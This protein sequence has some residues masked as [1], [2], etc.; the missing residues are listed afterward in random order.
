LFWFSSAVTEASPLDRLPPR[1][2]HEAMRIERVARPHTIV[3]V[4]LLLA[5]TGGGLA[6]LG[7]SG[8]LGARAVTPSE[9]ALTIGLMGSLILWH[10]PSNRIGLLLALTGVLF[11]VSVLA[12]GVLEYAGERGGAPGWLRQPAL[13]WAW[14]TP[15][16]ALPWALFLLWF[17]DGRFTS[18]G[19]KR[20]F[21]AATAAC[22]A[23]AVVGY[24][25]AARGGRLPALSP[26]AQAPAMAGGPLAISTS[27]RLGQL[28]DALPLL[29]PLVSLVSLAQRYR[30]SG[31][32]ARQQIKWLVAGAAVAIAG[33]A[34]A[35]LILDSGG[36]AHALGLAV[37]IVVNP[38]PVTA[39]AAAILRYHLWEIDVVVSRAVIYAVLWIV[40]SVVLL[41]PAL[42]AGLL[43]GGPGALAAVGLALLVT[44]AFQ[45]ARARLERAVERVV[46][47]D[48]QR[49]YAFLTRFGQTLRAATG[50]GEVAPQLAEVV[51]S[52]LGASWAGVWVHVAAEGGGA[53][54][55]VAAA[56]IEPGPSVLLPAET[57]ARLLSSPSRPVTRELPAE[58]RLL[59]PET[60]AAAAVPLVA[61]EKLVGVLA[62]GQ[63]PGDPLGERDH[64][65]LGQLARESALALRNLRLEAQLRERLTQIEQQAD[66][67]RRSRQRLV[68]VQDEERRRIERDLHDGVQQQLVALA[69][70]L[71]RAAIATPADAHLLLEQLAPEAEEAV[72]AL[73]DLARG[74]FP[75]VL[76]DQ[77]LAAALRTQAARMPMAIRVEAEPNLAGRRFDRE[78]EAACY[79][80]ALEA[81]ANAQKHAP[82]A[83]VTVSLRS[84]DAGRRIALEVH[85]DGPGFTEKLTSIGTGLQNMK[86]RLAAVG[87]ELAIDSRPGAGTWIRAQASAVA[88]VV[89]LQPDS[90]SFS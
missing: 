46:Y 13:A 66:E 52:G 70:R 76:A 89:A 31:A 40:L 36:A 81:M 11:G 79:F 22:L 84:A 18:R 80:V 2:E 1:P 27:A 57:Y 5:T 55:S 29:L 4:V 24:L 75:S 85:D 49:G 44:L 67:L 16:L 87:G 64:E 73:Q 77:G 20:F 60:T 8:R 34:I 23:L 65:L 54:R 28:I 15:A 53:L 68:G 19:W 35:S 82:G 25:V 32:I 71:R 72:F 26:V 90:G 21:A 61:G 50:V 3:V 78:L 83:A 7:L 10:R 37:V 47:R 30:R 17:P 45:P 39:A 33:S 12:G 56:G 48:R 6:L 86:D 14:L 63:R 43:V 42:A 74:I 58:L 9:L 59:W 69:A 51:R 41:V 88:S 62:C 38:L